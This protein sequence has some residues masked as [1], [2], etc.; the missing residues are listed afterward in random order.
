MP[1]FGDPLF[2]DS[3]LFKLLDNNWNQIP[4]HTCY[5][6]F[7]SALTAALVL[8]SESIIAKSIIYPPYYSLKLL[9]SIGSVPIM[10]ESGQHT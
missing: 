5:F 1:D 10:A 7:F 6:V 9:E 2:S 3:M 4:G 8:V